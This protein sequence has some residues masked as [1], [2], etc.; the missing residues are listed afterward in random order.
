M[1]LRPDIL[2][3]VKLFY[4]IC[5]AQNAASLGGRFGGLPVSGGS[6]QARKSPTTLSPCSFL[7]EVVVPT[8][9]RDAGRRAV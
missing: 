6:P 9:P 8:E 3:P 5:G 7:Y 1:L 4:T 2:R